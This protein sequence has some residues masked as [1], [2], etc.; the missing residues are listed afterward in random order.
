[1]VSDESSGRRGWRTRPPDRSAH[2]VPT[3]DYVRFP[4]HYRFRP[5]VCRAAV[6][7]KKGTVE[8]LVGYTK[9][10]LIVPTGAQ[11]RRP[12]SGQRRGGP[13]VRGVNA[14][15]HAEICAVPAERLGR[16]RPLLGGLRPL[17]AEIGPK[18]ISRKVNER[19]CVRL[20]QVAGL[21][22]LRQAPPGP[23]RRCSLVGVAESGHR[24]RRAV[25]HVKA[26][27]TDTR[28]P[29][30]PISQALRHPAVGVRCAPGVTRPTE[31]TAR[32]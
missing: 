21:V 23:M 3:T 26:A 24:L 32:I 30:A 4:K 1:M 2:T 22:V 15:V 9:R 16:E 31:R 27:V 5:D 11:P 8:H 17:R 7:E 20:R 13:L 10:D 28:S 18:P 19:S 25:E 29:K 6:P 14:A 12:G